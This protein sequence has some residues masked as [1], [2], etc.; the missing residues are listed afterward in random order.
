M[1]ELP[2]DPPVYTPPAERWFER[3]ECTGTT[4]QEMCQAL[5]AMWL[6]LHDRMR[7]PLPVKPRLF[8]VVETAMAASLF[9]R[10][11]PGAVMAAWRSACDRAPKDEK[12]ETVFL[13]LLSMKG[14]KDE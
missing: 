4:R 12:P 3:Y 5:S 13:N 9:T 8:T 1:K 11:G 7:L 6:T 2:P 14:V 10:K